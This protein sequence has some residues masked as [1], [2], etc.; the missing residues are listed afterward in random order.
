M[1]FVERILK[2]LLKKHLSPFLLNGLDATNVKVS[3]GTVR[4]DNLELNASVRSPLLAV[5]CLAPLTWH[6]SSIPSW[7]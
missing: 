7:E 3:S 4:L 2:Q 5:A 1:A 6:R